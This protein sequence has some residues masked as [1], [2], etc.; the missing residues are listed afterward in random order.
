[1]EAVLSSAPPAL[2]DALGRLFKECPEAAHWMVPVA[3]PPGRLPQAPQGG[4]LP[5]LSIRAF[6]ALHVRSVASQEVRHRFFSSGSTGVSDN[7]LIK[8]GSHDMSAAGLETYGRSSRRGY[9]TFAERLGISP[10][11][12]FISLVP[13][14]EQ[15]PG[16]SL[17]TM[18]ELLGQG[19]HSVAPVYWCTTENLPRALAERVQ[20]HSPAGASEIAETKDIVLFGTTLHHHLVAAHL[21]TQAEGLP[22]GAFNGSEN[23]RL[24][25][26]DTGGA[27]GKTVIVDAAR[28]AEQLRRCYSRSK[29]GPWRQVILASEYGMC[30]L[31][32]QAWSLADNLR[33]FVTSPGLSVVVVDPD[34]L[35]AARERQP[36]FLAFYDEANTDS[37]PAILTEDMGISEQAH[38]FVLLGRGPMASVKGCSLRIGALPPPSPHAHDVAA[39]QEHHSTQVTS[40]EQHVITQQG[41]PKFPAPS[42]PT[43]HI[44]TSGERPPFFTAREWQALGRAWDSWTSVAIPRQLSPGR[45]TSEDRKLLIVAAAN[46]C[47]AL[48]YPICAAWE[49]GY[50]SVSVALPGVRD[51]DPLAPLVRQQIDWLLSRLSR[52]FSAREAGAM[53][54]TSSRLSAT[55]V[56]TLMG[57]E[58][59]LLFGSDETIRVYQSALHEAQAQVRLIG[60]GDVS[61]VL[62]AHVDD[63]AINLAEICLA[64]RGRGCL[65]PRAI[66]VRDGGRLQPNPCYPSMDLAERLAQ[67]MACIHAEEFADVPADV[68]RM[69]HW[70]SLREVEACTHGRAR[71][72]GNKGCAVVDVRHLVQN[73]TGGPYGPSS[74]VGLDLGLAG[75]GFVYL[76]DEQSFQNWTQAWGVPVQRCNPNPSFSDAHL[77][78]S[79]RD[80]LA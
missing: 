1:M 48:L 60:M 16:S 76:V 50:R 40:P 20:A 26:V 67:A 63:D 56:R 33:S 35:A 70:H 25:V 19:G 71:I 22:P 52:L 21:D 15:W 32:S 74:E 27:K 24:I 66:V 38:E 77:G 44:L 47:I 41:S 31:A 78:K 4:I 42:V 34:S 11:S 37:Y 12:P 68:L 28:H 79:W 13:R 73:I 61:N 64:W 53:H 8:R 29:L 57:F 49:Q 69:Y 17:A 58:T 62:E 55:D 36:G 46:A 39:L 80:W 7:G 45:R 43:S 10:H 14:P 18:I 30:E 9:T 23:C 51:D 2:R 75:Q 3:V 59:V 72:L 6:K 65:T 5:F 54:V